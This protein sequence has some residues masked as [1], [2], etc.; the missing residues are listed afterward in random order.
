MFIGA[1]CTF[2]LTQVAI[3]PRLMSREASC[4]RSIVRI[5]RGRIKMVDMSAI[6]GALGSL[7]TLK[8]LAQ[9]MIGLRDAQA[10]QAKLIEFQSAVL[11]AQ[12]SVFAANEERTALVEKV[13]ELEADMAR[14][15]AWETEK[16][17][18]KLERLEPGIFVYS[19][20]PEMAAGEPAHT[21][22]QTC[23]QRGS[24]SILHG[25]EPMNGLQELTCFECGTKLIA[26]RFQ[27]RGPGRAISDYN[28]F[29]D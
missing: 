15:K 26:G 5:K 8:N 10:F 2:I 25:S 13:R 23:Y 14:L 20:K 1:E 12:S 7:N 19:L 21:I 24:K 29:P 3:P 28:P 4:Q 17:R 16:Q 27:S 11:D 18:Y 6:A 22:C 9:A